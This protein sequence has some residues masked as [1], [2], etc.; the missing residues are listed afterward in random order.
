MPEATPAAPVAPAAAPKRFEIPVFEEQ[1]AETV[2]APSPAAAVVPDGQK[3]LAGEAPATPQGDEKPPTT[4]QDPE[5]QSSRR[6]ERRLDK[7]Y[8]RAAEAQARADLLQKQIDELKPKAPV[9]TGAPRLEQF[10]DIE[11][12]ATAKAKYEREKGIKEYQATQSTQTAKQAQTALTS[13]WEKKAERAAAKYDDFDEIV[14]EL[15]PENIVV[16]AIMEAENAEDV[17]YYLFKDGKKEAIRIGKLPVLA[18]IRAIGHI[19]AKLAAEPPKPKTP[20]KAPAPITPV[21]GVAP[22]TTDVPSEQDEI[23]QW[24]KK[25]SKQV[26]GKR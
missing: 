3:P 11:E 6:F 14:P 17:A 16:A 2:V 24:L 18:Q 21:S 22:T 23:G 26:H 4:G 1:T 10:N 8:R 25:R 15:S 5:K 13:E 7:A 12:Y 9:D 19:E 20:S